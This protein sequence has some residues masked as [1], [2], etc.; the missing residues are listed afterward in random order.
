MTWNK[1]DVVKWHRAHPRGERDEEY[2][3]AVLCRVKEL[4]MQRPS[5]RLGQ[6]LLNESYHQ[7]RE[8]FWLRDEEWF[9]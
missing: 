1:A 5:E 6:M 4:W 2:I 7:A 8:I 9:E 3:D